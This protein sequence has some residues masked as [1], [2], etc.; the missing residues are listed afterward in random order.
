MTLE[1]L[2]HCPLCNSD[3]YEL[4]KTV[5]D[6]T[7]SQ[8]VFNIVACGNCSFLY[9]NPRPNS[10]SLGA[11]YKSD[12][13]ISHTNKSNNPINLIY[14]LARTQTL[15][16]KYNL[17]AKTTPKSILDYGCGTG[18]F[19]NYCKK[20]GLDVNGFE[21]DKE[22]RTIAIQ[23]V[24]NVIASTNFDIQKKFDVITLW[25]VLEHIP[26]L[27]EVVAWLKN[28]L[29]KNGRLIIAVPNPKS[30]DAQLFKEY[31]AAYDVPRHLYHFSKKTLED[32]ANR[33]SFSLE[34]IHPMK[35]DS[36]YVSL[37]SNQHKYEATKPIKSFLNGLKSNSYAKETMNYSSL[38]YVLKH[39]NE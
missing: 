13:Y 26:N 25:H 27:N 34:S 31:W 32:L 8:E 35:L 2:T 14:K 29:A 6:Y 33:H 4:H 39:H 20:K 15:K 36:F 10:E 5:K 21:P 16:W 30:Y 17:I 18:H 12:N 37:L 7:V 11:Y 28:H 22:A 24:G 1:K 19:L 9:T 23:E 3:K 38:I